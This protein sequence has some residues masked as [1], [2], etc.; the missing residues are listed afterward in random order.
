MTKP[1][2]EHVL[3]AAARA[4]LRD[5]NAAYGGPEQSFKAIAILWNDY[6]LCSNK[7]AFIFEPHDVAA[8]M[9]LLKVAR[10]IHNPTHLDSW[11]DIAGYAACGA[12][13]AKKKEP[14]QS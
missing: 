8:L 12:E 7:S 1:I 11:V 5:R 9:I 6:L 14:P 4:V 13:C 10:L 3:D 2:R